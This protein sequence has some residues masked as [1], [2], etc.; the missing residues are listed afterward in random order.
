M[1]WFRTS[2]LENLYD[3]AVNLLLQVHSL[4]MSAV[5]QWM[6]LFSSYRETQHQARSEW[7][8][9]KKGVLSLF[10]EYHKSSEFTV[11]IA[12]LHSGKS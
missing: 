11:S 6:P 5:I 12:Q 8:C 4:L 2:P 1:P 3:K 10:Y 7:L 9:F